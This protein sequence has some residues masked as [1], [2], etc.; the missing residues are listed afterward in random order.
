MKD[1]LIVEPFDDELDWPQPPDQQP[2]NMSSSFLFG[3]RA[4]MRDAN[5]LETSGEEVEFLTT[6]FIANVDPLIKIFHVLSLRKLM[7]SISSDLSD[8]RRNRGENAIVSA[9]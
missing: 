4:C 1:D 5:S 8:I 6:T 2:G 3:P 7:R 9:V